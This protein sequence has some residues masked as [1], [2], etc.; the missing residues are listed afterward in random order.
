MKSIHTSES[1]GSIVSFNEDGEVIGFE[2]AAI[3]ASASPFAIATM[4]GFPLSFVGVDQLRGQ[5]DDI[6][7]LQPTKAASKLKSSL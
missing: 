1:S 2:G 3:L 6:L 7:A 4:G 5:L